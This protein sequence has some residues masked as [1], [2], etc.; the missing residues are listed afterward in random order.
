MSH[1]LHGHCPL[2][3][4][5]ALEPQATETKE[6]VFCEFTISVLLFHIPQ[7]SLTRADAQMNLSKGCC[8]CCLVCLVCAG[9]LFVR[10][11]PMRIF[12][13]WSQLFV[14]TGFC[15]GF[16]SPLTHS[17]KY[18]LHLCAAIWTCYFEWSFLEW[19]AFKPEVFFFPP[20][21][22]LMQAKFHFCPEALKLQSTLRS[23]F[24]IYVTRGQVA[25][26]RDPGCYDVTKGAQ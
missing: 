3:L 10:M 16:F 20:G 21:M 23:S 14:L 8:R 19:W 9:F 12:I 22:S 7:V 13:L 26:C 1:H 24:R 6:L 18:S 17:T 15:T 4:L 11:S 25:L 5:L 2:R